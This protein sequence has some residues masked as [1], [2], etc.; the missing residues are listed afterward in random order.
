MGVSTFGYTLDATAGPRWSLMVALSVL[1]H[2]GVITSVLFYP[3]SIPTRKIEGQV[4]EVE[5]VEISSPRAGKT[6]KSA[7]VAPVDSRPVET[8]KSEGASS[9]VDAKP[10]RRIETVKPVEKPA[11]IAKR[12]VDKPAPAAPKPKVNPAEL[13]GRAVSRV[14]KKVESRREDPT[15]LISDA[16][17][18]IQREVE[19]KKKEDSVIGDAIARL[20]EGESKA[21]SSGGAP[22]GGSGTSIRARLYEMQVREHISHNWTYPAALDTAS[23]NPEAEVVV[24]VRSDGSIIGYEISRKSANPRFDQ[25]VLKAVERSNPLPRL[26]EGYGKSR[27]VFILTFSLDGLLH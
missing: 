8:S 4:Y 21:S 25:S 1:L 7:A 16:V 3:A 2:A 24:Q 18:R 10:A 22:S 13:I 27:E 9:V 23:G 20:N 17:N 15:A 6:G 5:L 19:E 26:P 12:V 14:E 11:V